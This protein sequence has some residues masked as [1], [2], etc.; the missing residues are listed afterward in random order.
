VFLRMRSVILLINECDDDDDDDLTTE[1]WHVEK[2]RI[3]KEV[4]ILY[5][6]R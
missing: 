5:K 2:D 3:V 1:Q 4:D 6:L